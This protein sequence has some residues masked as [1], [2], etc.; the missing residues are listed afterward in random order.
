MMTPETRSDSAQPASAILPLLDDALSRLGNVDR[1]VIV[2]RFIR[3]RTHSQVAVELGMSEQAASKRVARAL[4][5]L[6][7]IL[8]RRGVTA[9][10]L[11]LSSMLPATLLSPGASPALL[12]AIHSAIPA[13]TVAPSVVAMA[14]RALRPRRWVLIAVGAAMII[15]IGGAFI[16]LR[17]ETRKL[18]GLA[19]FSR[20]SAPS[21]PSIAGAPSVTL[22][23]LDSLTAQPLGGAQVAIDIDGNRQL[24]GTAGADGKYTFVRPTGFQSLG[25]IARMPGKVPMSLSFQNTALRGDLLSAYSIPMEAGSPIGGIVT[26]ERGQA[27]ADAQVTLSTFSAATETP[28]P[29]LPDEIVRT[30]ADGRWRFD[31]APSRFDEVLVQIDRLGFPAGQYFQATAAELR[32]QTFRAVLK[33]QLGATLRGVVLDPQG[34]GVKGAIVVAAY[35]RNAPNKPVARSDEAGRFSIGG[36]SGNAKMAITATAPGFAPGQVVLANGAGEVTDALLKIQLPLPVMLQGRV[37]DVGGKPVIGARVELAKWRGNGA[38]E[39]STETDGDGRFQWNAAPAD[40]LQLN[41]SKESFARIDRAEVTPGAAPVTLIVY[42]PLRISGH[43]ID[44][45]TR[46][47]VPE[48]RIVYGIRWTGDDDV[49]WQTQSPRKL[50]QGKYEGE[51]VDFSNGGK[52]RVEADGYLPVESRLIQQSEGAISLDFEMKRVGRDLS[53]H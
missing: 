3:G 23:M 25:V 11:L 4:E 15:L 41:V 16:A 1:D 29:I 42:P 17:G 37:V 21:F 18:P 12:I 44:A 10:D 45:A 7:S 8:E 50:G 20:T 38:L 30:G 27:L 53:R 32:D 36:I 14:K 5:K 6:R 22:S 24:P 49:T 33:H 31:H 39:W 35:N 34:R 19:M 28:S 46:Q 9:G 52:L 26:D 51:I 40:V 43:V 48:F 13:G 47:P 2:E